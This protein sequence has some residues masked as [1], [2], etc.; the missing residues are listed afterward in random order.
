MAGRKEYE[1]MFKLN[2]QVSGSFH[3]GMKHANAVLVSM[4]KEMN[5]LKHA[6]SDI[7]A[8]QKQQQAVELTKKKL[9]GLQKQ[10]DNIQKQIQETGKFSSALENKLIDK[11]HQIDKTNVSLEQQTGKLYQMKASLQE[12]G[13]DTEKLT[14][15]QKRLEQETQQLKERQAEVAES[16]EEFGN[17]TVDA[18]DA[19]SSAIAAAGIAAALNQIKDAFME[20]IEVAGAYEETLSTVEALSGASEGEM[21]ELSG[22]AKKLGAETQYTAQES[23]DAMTYMAM[24]GWETADMLNGM[25]GVLQLAAA[26]GEDLALVSDIVTDNL[27]AF[28]MSAADTAH[29]S[30][31]LASAATSSN[32]SVSIM[33]ETFKQSASIAGA[34]G[35]SVDDV[36]VAVGLMANSGVKGSMAGTALKNTFNGLLEGVE[37]TGS[38]LGEYEF[39][40]Q[41]SDGTMKSFAETINELR[42]VFGQMTEAEKTSNAMAIAGSRSYNG[43]LAIVNA[44]DEDFNSLSNSITN[45]SGAASKMASVKMDNMAGDLKLA[46]SAWEGVTIAVGEQFTPVMRKAYQAAAEVF[47]WMKD[48]VEEHPAVVKAVTAFVAVIGTATAAMTAYAAI[49]KVVK[50]LDLATLFT[51]PTGMILGAVAAVAGLTAGVVALVSSVNE[52]VPSVKELTEAAR[53]MDEAMEQAQN[54]FE[55]TSADMAATASV[56]EIYITRLEELEAELGENAAKNQEYHNILELLTRT[57]PE[58]ADSIDLETNAIEGGTQALRRQTEEWKR[59]AE[60]RARQEYLN[61]LYDEYSE[62]MSEA[63]ENEI[64]LTQA[65]MKERKAVEDQEEAQKRMNELWKEAQ[66]KAQQLYEETGTLTDACDLLPGEYYEASAAVTEYDNEIMRLQKEQENLKD[67]IE[68]DKEVVTEAESVIKDAEAAIEEMTEAERKAA[69][70]AAELSEQNAMVSETVGDISS[71]AEELAKRYEEAYSA[72]RD[73]ISGQYELW[74]QAAKVSEKSAGDMASSMGSQAQ[75]WQDY[76]ANLSSLAERAKDVEGLRDVVASFA[77]GSEESVNAIA[78]MASASD[79]DLQAMAENWKDLQNAQHAASGS[80]AD[81]KED[82]TNEMDALGNELA[83]DI[84]KMN[85]SDEAATAAKETIQGF[86]DGASG[87]LGQVRAAYARVASE[88]K[89]AL[90][91]TPSGS[92]VRPGTGGNAPAGRAYA[93]GTSSAERGFALVG[94]EG[95]EIVFMNGGETVLNAAETSK[96]Q[97]ELSIGNLQMRAAQ[98]Q[99]EAYEAQ[100]RQDAAGPSAAV[101]SDAQ[102]GVIVHVYSSPTIVVEGEGAQGLEEAQEEYVQILVERVKEALSCGME[103]RTQYA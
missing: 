83:A 14:E 57:I 95:P 38:A 51:G 24:A 52:G 86:V 67:A 101:G 97:K 87:M 40:A 26:S 22:M 89:K 88:A 96:V 42:S 100:P 36:A 91:G 73:S 66:E 1:L 60:E 53:E 76:N 6:Q 69:G 74:E 23:A 54:E 17:G 16:A 15:E 27:T 98:A 3:G 61:G 45:C 32:T 29:F 103:G 46:Q 92:G 102:G 33:G 63:A 58:L 99:T 68:E 9:E 82:F 94:E 55:E 78:G 75:Y 84:E 11:Q 2:S 19:I 8:Y 20:C 43:L 4:Q 64:K 80:I 39:S 77:D 28:G 31:V 10:Y 56:A 44:A 65:E 85:L 5:S 90:S 7:S 25:D 37:L 50:L 70:E 79:S 35:Y 34:L 30:D 59:N 81:L 21:E 41:K 71:R 18:M 47:S 13:V 48:F 49:V 12:A 93:S 72:A 62:V